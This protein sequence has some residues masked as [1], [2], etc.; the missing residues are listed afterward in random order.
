M[1]QRILSE[2]DGT[3]EDKKKW[4]LFLVG[5]G[6]EVGPAIPIILLIITLQISH[7]VSQGSQVTAGFAAS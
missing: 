7:V 2:S 1:G 5:H 4:R 6:Q 3:R